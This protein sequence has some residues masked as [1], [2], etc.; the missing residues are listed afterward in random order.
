VISKLFSWLC[1]LIQGSGI[2][3]TYCSFRSSCRRKRVWIFLLLWLTL[4]CIIVRS[5]L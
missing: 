3:R 2:A 1:G 5:L 4:Y